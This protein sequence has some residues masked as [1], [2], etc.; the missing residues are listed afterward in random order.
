MALV[1]SVLAGLIVA[2][3]FAFVAFATAGAV[4]ALRWRWMPW[5]HVPAAGWAAYIE[6]SG[7]ICPLTPL[8]N[9]FRARA[10]LDFYSG[11][12][13]A[14]HL[15]PLLYPTGLSRT[16][17]TALGLTVIILNLAVYAWLVRRRTRAT[18]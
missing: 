15:F 4:L 11:D 14:R 8:E 6:L 5:L 7:G 18:V 1:W 10:G 9:D 12:F 16:A 17:Q 2:L 3:H 13:V